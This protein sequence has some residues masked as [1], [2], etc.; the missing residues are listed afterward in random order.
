MSIPSHPLDAFQGPIRSRVGGVRGGEYAIFRGYDIHRDLKDIH[1]VEMLVFS[2]TG[3]RYTPAQVR[4]FNAMMTF[5]SYP[6]TRIWNNRVAALAGS[7]RSTG[8]LAASAALAVSEAAIFGRQ[9]DY[10]ALDFLARAKAA[11]DMGEDLGKFVANDLNQHRSIAGFG[12]P[13]TA[14]DE[15]MIPM[16]NL[17][18]QEGLNDGPYLR[19]ARE[20]EAILLSGRWRFSMNYAGLVAA[21]CGDFG[22]SPDEYVL[23]AFPVFVAG[24]IPCYLEA[25]EKPSGAIMALRCEDMSFSGC[26][27]RPWLEGRA[28]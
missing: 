25:R 8:G 26:Q 9:V 12:R 4:V 13:I 10:R 1:W 27:A 23:A 14:S 20:V 15:R 17:L 6:D 16:V 19:I 22:L 18:E 24:M 28:T 3:K 5:T 11:K 2:V 21:I 7:A